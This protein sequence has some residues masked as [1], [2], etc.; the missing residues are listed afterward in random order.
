M[1]VQYEVSRSPPPSWPKKLSPQQATLPDRSAQLWSPPTATAVT[2]E[3]NPLTGAATVLGVLVPFPS[4]PVEL[5]PQHRTWPPVVS[6][7][8]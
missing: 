2:P 7:H 6:A 3:D 1:Y 5:F 8:E 4:W